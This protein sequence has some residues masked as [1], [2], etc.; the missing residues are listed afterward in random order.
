MTTDAEDELHRQASRASSKGSFKAV[1]SVARLGARITHH[2]GKDQ[3][4]TPDGKDESS[5]GEEENVDSGYGDSSLKAGDVALA[6]FTSGAKEKKKKKK[7]IDQTATMVFGAAK[8]LYGK[9][10]STFKRTGGRQNSA[11]VQTSPTHTGSVTSISIPGLV[12]TPDP[13]PESFYQT[14]EPRERAYFVYLISDSTGS[15]FRKD[16]IGRVQLPHGMKQVTLADLRAMMSR[17]DD[18][19]LRGML[20]NNKSFRFVTETYKFVAQNEQ[21]AEIDE[22]YGQ[23]GIFVKFMEGSDVKLTLREGGPSPALSTRIRS[24]QKGGRKRSGRRRGG[25]HAKSDSS[26]DHDDLPP[27]KHKSRQRLAAADQQH[28]DVSRS[29]DD[30]K[31]RGSVTPMDASKGGGRD[32]ITPDPHDPHH[33]RRRRLS[34]RGKCAFIPLTRNRPLLVSTT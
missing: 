21:A 9:G 34:F 18:A 31:R 33:R 1:A 23:Q 19:T 24:R 13:P 3:T 12:E 30:G 29:D 10:Q 27:L 28:H 20:R 4:S 32:S 22:V 15:N 8:E 17:S 14:P 7:K 25:R 11:G 5:S 16:C 26:T 2:P 6:A